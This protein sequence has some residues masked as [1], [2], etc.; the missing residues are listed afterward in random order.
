MAQKKLIKVRTFPGAIIQDF[1]I[2][3][4]NSKASQQKA[5]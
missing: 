2:Q 3:V 4:F 1:T 5:R